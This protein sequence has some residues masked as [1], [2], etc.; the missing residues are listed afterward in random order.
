MHLSHS[1]GQSTYH[2]IWKPKWCH[3]ILVGGVQNCCITSLNR[4]CKNH[5]MKMI[6]REVM[7]DHI[8]WFIK[9]KPTMSVSRCLQLLKG[10]SSKKLFEFFPELRK[11]IYNRIFMKSRKIFQKCRS[12][13][14]RCNKKL[15]NIF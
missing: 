6:E 11:K 15:H 12:N 3:R 5:D 13:Y 1:V 2:L 10:Y 14:R 8:H 7:P 9:I 4:A